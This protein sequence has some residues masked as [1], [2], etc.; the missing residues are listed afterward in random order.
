MIKSKASGKIWLII[1]REYITR[2]RKKTFLI[3]TLLGPLLFGSMMLAPAWF[4][5][6]DDKEVRVIAVVD[7][8]HLFWHKLPETETI[9]FRYLPNANLKKV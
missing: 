3:M 5:K 1:K 7:S 4:A 6:M 8:S 9:K 2:V